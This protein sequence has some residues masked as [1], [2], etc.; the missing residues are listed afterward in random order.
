MAAGRSPGGTVGELCM[1]M[2]PGDPWPSTPMPG[3]AD[4]LA[5]EFTAPPELKWA[6]PMPTGTAPMPR[7]ESAVTAA[8]IKGML[9][10]GPASGSVMSASSPIPPGA[11]WGTEEVDTVT[12]LPEL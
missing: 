4:R 9:V 7:A 10:P 6:Y 11:E 2:S 3:L 12:R 5:M 8:V 1:P